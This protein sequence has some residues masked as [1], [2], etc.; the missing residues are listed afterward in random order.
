MLQLFFPLSKF[1]PYDCFDN[2]FSIDY[3]KLYEDGKRIILMDIDNTLIPYDKV[4]PTVEIIEL[5]DKI[6]KIG[7]EIILI[8]NNNRERVKTFADELSI[9][10]INN[11]MKPF[12]F[13]YRKIKKMIKPHTKDEVIAI[14]D[15]L[16][17]DILGAN[18]HH[19]DAILVKPIQRKSE[20]WYT[21]FN[22]RIEERVMRKMKVKYPLSYQKIQRMKE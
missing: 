21:K 4:L 9:P 1:I 14:G 2:I 15:Q 8:S 20:K 6:Q 18:R 19:I 12:S 7:L 11:A 17:T 10:Y 5:F 13:A 16:L 22:R 3:N